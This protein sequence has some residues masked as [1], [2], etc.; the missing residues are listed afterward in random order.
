MLVKFKVFDKQLKIVRQFKNIDYENSEI[1]F[2][3]YVN[4]DGSKIETYRNFD[5]VIFL[6]STGLIDKDG[7]EIYEGDICVY[8]YG[9]VAEYCEVKWSEKYSTW[10][11]E[12]DSDIE[13]LRDFARHIS[14]EVI[15]NI[16]E[17]SHLFQE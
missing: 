4:E 10:M 2:I 11:I 8:Y 9:G 15:G 3:S 16:Y 14:F 1:L 17:V 7:A 6:M 12:G 5:D 13:F